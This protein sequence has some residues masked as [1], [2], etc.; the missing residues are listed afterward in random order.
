MNPAGKFNLSVEW[1]FD[2]LR[3]PSQEQLRLLDKEL[4]F[5]AIRS[6]QALTRSL[7]VIIEYGREGACP[8]IV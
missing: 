8:S 6:E 1:E 3:S 4:A 5:Y 2:I 7:R